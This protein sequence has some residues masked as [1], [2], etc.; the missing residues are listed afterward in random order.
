VYGRTIA[1]A[2][3]AHMV[4]ELARGVRFA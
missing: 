2:R 3:E 1:D 4:V